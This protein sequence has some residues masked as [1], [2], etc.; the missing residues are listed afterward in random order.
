MTWKNLFWALLGAIV[1]GSVV[2]GV[3][4]RYVVPALFR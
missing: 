1:V 2:V 3:L 4:F